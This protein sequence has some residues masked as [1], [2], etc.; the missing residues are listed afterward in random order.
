MSLGDNCGFCGASPSC[1]IKLHKLGGSIKMVESA[2]P[3]SFAVR[4]WL[5]A[6]KAQK[7]LW[8]TN[9]PVVCKI[10]DPMPLDHH[11]RPAV[12]KYNM[13]AH[14]RTCHPDYATPGWPAHPG[15]HSACAGQ[16]GLPPPADMSVE[17][18]FRGEEARLGLA[19]SMAW[20]DLAAPPS[21]P[22][23]ANKRSLTESDGSPAPFK[24]SRLS[25][26]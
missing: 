4:S 1:A 15:V 17:L 23:P 16:V 11:P 14:I 22:P 8:T 10:C 13:E 6:N 24:K 18:N 25:D 9:V 12:W 21:I 2:C 26:C 19:T 3:H 5:D 7:A 20:T